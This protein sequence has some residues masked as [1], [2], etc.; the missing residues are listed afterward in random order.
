[1]RRGAA[2]L[3][4][5]C[6]CALLGLQ[7]P[8]SGTGTHPLRGTW[9]WGRPD[10][11]AL[12]AF[13]TEQGVDD[14]FVHVPTVIGPAD[15]S[16]LAELRTRTGEAGIRIHAL[17]SDPG[18]LTDPSAALAWQDAAL[19]TGFFDGTHLDV[20]PW[21]QP[22]WANKA[23]RTRLISRYVDLL[24]RLT[25]ASDLPVEADIPFWFGEHTHARQPLDV[26]VM[27]RVDAVTVMTYRNTVTGPDSITALGRRALDVGR[28]VGR[29]VRLAVE[30]N[31]LG[32][33]PVAR[34]QTFFGQSRTR[35]TSALSE[36]DSIEAG[37]PAYRGVAVHDSAGWI[38][39]AP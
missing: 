21:V 18:W 32:E 5:V 6:C 39:M 19:A 10:P 7:P 30:T 20:E 37:E 38:A 11:A 27:Q 13:A 4:M 14:L 17:G 1:M 8:A 29:P 34:K 16:W 33:D 28:Q 12:T 2:F 9:V 26:A 31:Y 36:V 15:R 23:K 25:R 3:V 24:D 35:L 22:G